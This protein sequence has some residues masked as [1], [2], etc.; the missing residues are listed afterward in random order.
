M[1]TD[2]SDAVKA[3][4]DG[5]TTVFQDVVNNVL[6]DK[7][8]ERIGVEKVAVAQSF[9]NEPEDLDSPDTLENSEEISNEDV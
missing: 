7:L 2:V 4:F 1:P 6:T 8:R 5:N 9:F 3:A